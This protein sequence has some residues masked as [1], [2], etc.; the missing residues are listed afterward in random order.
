MVLHGFAS[1]KPANK[2][3][4]MKNTYY[5]PKIGTGLP[6]GSPFA[7]ANISADPPAVLKKAYGIPLDETGEH[8]NTSMMVV[9][10]GGNS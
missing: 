8:G 4:T 1:R 3:K 6:S 9:E 7:D 2:N 5:H 10:F